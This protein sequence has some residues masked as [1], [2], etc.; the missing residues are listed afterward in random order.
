M[1]GDYPIRIVTAL[2]GELYTRDGSP[3]LPEGTIGN[4]AKRIK[5][6]SNMNKRKQI[7]VDTMLNMDYS[8]L[9]E[10]MQYFGF[11]TLQQYID[12]CNDCYAHVEENELDSFAAQ[13]IKDSIDLTRE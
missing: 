8:I 9:Q 12:Y 4:I 13:L 6:N 3:T 7:I 5:I 2:S 1:W 10:N 11:K